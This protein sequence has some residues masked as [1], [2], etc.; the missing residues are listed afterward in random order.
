ML[1]TEVVCLSGIKSSVY[2]IRER[3]DDGRT[4]NK[5]YCYV[6]FNHFSL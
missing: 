4:K 1:T 6:L 5:K 2:K 3:N